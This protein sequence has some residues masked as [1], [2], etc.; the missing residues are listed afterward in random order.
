MFNLEI[1]YRE[2][3]IVNVDFLNTQLKCIFM[4]KIYCNQR[5]ENIVS[6]A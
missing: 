5:F 1:K 3:R 4:R 6:K 2:F